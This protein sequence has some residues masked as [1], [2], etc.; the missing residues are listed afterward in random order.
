MSYLLTF[1]EVK[2]WHDV[3][4]RGSTVSAFLRQLAEEKGFNKYQVAS[5][6]AEI[7]ED[8]ISGEDRQVLWKWRFSESDEGFDDEE[9]DGLLTH[10]LS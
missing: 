4:R 2:N 3:A 7:F 9:I 10:L 6:A 5:A 8:R 1:E